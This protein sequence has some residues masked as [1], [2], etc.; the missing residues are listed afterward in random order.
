[1]AKIR[2]TQIALTST[3]D[4]DIYGEYLDTEGRVW[5]QTGHLDNPDD[6]E[7]RKWVPEWKQLELPDE[8]KP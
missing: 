6:R 7:R 4:G 3:D 5:Y 1:M 8:P 2:V